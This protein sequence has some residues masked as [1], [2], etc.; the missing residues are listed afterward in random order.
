MRTSGCPVNGRSAADRTGNRSV[1]VS[2]GLILGLALGLSAILAAPCQAGVSISIYPPVQYVE[3]DEVFNAYV[4]VDSAGSEFSAYYAEI[5]FDP[6]ALEFLSVQEE[7]L[8]V[9]LCGTTFFPDPVLGDSTIAITHVALCGGLTL[10]GPGV[11]SSVTFRA[12]EEV[13]TEVSFD[14]LLCSVGGFPVPDVEGHSGY[15]LVGE[16]QGIES[17]PPRGAAPRL[18]ATPRVA[19]EAVQLKFDLP[20]AG[21]IELRAHDLTGRD[22]GRVYAGWRPAGPG[23][24]IWDTA[25]QPAESGVLFLRLSTSSG[26]TTERVTLIR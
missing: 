9:D 15:V 23:V 22:R 12:L 21:R 26:A 20:D 24:I 8:M 16:A 3:L 7:S 17:G 14:S 19:R 2:L 11:L 10:T 13:T 4:W 5:R 18:Q 6:T 1:I 25:D